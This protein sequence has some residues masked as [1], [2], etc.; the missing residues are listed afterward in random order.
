[1]R[2]STPEQI[3]GLSKQMAKFPRYVV[4]LGFED[5]LAQDKSVATAWSSWLTI[6]TNI[7]FKMR[8]C[9]TLYLKGHQNYDRSKIK[10]QF[11]CNRFV[12]FDFNLL[13]F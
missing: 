5:S 7:S 13:Y 9:M 3:Q 11:S 12:S 1:M 4:K 10:L 2:N 6:T 8:Y